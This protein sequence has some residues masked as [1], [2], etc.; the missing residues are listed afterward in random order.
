MNNCSRLVTEINNIV[1][2]GLVDL[3]AQR[4]FYVRPSFV[5][6]V[7]NFSSVNTEHIQIRHDNLFIIDTLHTINSTTQD[8]IRQ[9]KRRHSNILS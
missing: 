2:L 7:D 1:L 9:I 6:V 8:S 4:L 3:S 5:T